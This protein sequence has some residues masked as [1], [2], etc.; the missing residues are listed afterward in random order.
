MVDDDESILEII[1]ELL[2]KVFPKATIETTSDGYEACIKAGVLIPDII[3]L[4]LHLPKADGFEV[5]KSIRRVEFTKHA[6]IIVISG[7]LDKENRTRLQSF[8]VDKMFSKPFR[9]EELISAIEQVYGKG[10]AVI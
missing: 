4:D 6:E 2:R 8:G 7:Y 3:V 9:P 5:C 1:S 10:N